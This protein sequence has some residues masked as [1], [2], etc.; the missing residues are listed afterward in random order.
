MQYIAAR[1]REELS[2]AIE[3]SQDEY[4]S[5]MA[6]Y[7]VRHDKGMRLKTLLN[8]MSDAYGKTFSG[9]WW[10]G[11]REEFGLVGAVRALE[12]TYGQSGWHPHYHVILF[13]SRNML[14]GV[15]DGPILPEQE[16]FANPT[17]YAETLTDVIQGR[18]LER[19]TQVGLSGE[20]DIAFDLRASDRRVAEYI[21]KYGTMPQEW[22]IN[23]SPYEVASAHTKN[24]RKG[25]F[26][27]LDMLFHAPGNPRMKN[28]FLEYHDATKGKSSIQWSPKLKDL[29]DIELIRDSM[30]AQGVE[31]ETDRLLAEIKIDF[32]RYIV[33]RGHLGQVMTYANAGE[34]GK[35]TRLLE[36]IYE[37]RA[38]ET[39]N[40]PQWDLGH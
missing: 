37:K 28:L 35:L 6:T 30:A 21:S 34:D 26:G 29:L 7:T 40:L 27:A 32:W 19:L 4:F 31:T 12:V 14:K 36:R 2:A 5:L 20:K 1:R 38:L 17:E 9:R 10:K 23:A 8:Q 15:Y 33:D 11:T 18:W 25:N 24:A 16:I 22:Q 3:N 39:V 13:V